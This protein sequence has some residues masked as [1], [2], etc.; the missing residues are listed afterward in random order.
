MS[1]A[2]ARL[3]SG[4]VLTRLIKPEIDR[5]AIPDLRSTLSDSSTGEPTADFGETSKVTDTT[6]GG[7]FLRAR[8]RFV[9]V[10]VDMAK[11]IDEAEGGSGRNSK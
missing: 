9:G 4:S 11:S 7:G 10:I 8:E 2:R 5:F 1:S 6:E 3:T